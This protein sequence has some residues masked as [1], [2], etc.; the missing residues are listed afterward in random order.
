[1]C[2]S[3]L[4]LS[5]CGGGSE[6][7]GPYTSPQVAKAFA[8][9]TGD[10]LTSA[11]G[12]SNAIYEVLK[13]NERGDS[14]A[15]YERYGVFSVYVLNKE[16]ARD[17]VYRRDPDTKKAIKPSSDGIY[18]RSSTSGGHVSWSAAKPFK[19]AVLTW[20]AGE[21]QQTDERWNRLVRIMRALDKSPA[22][23][24]A[25]LPPGDQ[26]CAQ[27]GIDPVRGKTGTC[28]LE[29]QTLVLANRSGPLTLPAL[30][31]VRVD[32]V[33]RTKQVKRRYLGARRAR[34]TYVIVRYTVKNTGRAPLSFL[35]PVLLIGDRSYES[36]SRT[37]FDV[38]PRRFDAYP[39]QPDQT[40]PLAAVFDVPPAAA[41]QV[42]AA[43][44]LA[45]SGDER[46][47]GSS[48]VPNAKTV[49]RIRLNQ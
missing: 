43:G 24:R 5:A 14:L 27:Q 12:A 13:L 33:R 37:E 34:G 19:N 15:S 1:M 16:Q 2:L 25:L 45:I 44:A 17:I 6:K 20:Q 41:A 38:Q 46:G 28:K 49:G 7:L 47:S 35:R 21:R 39:I 9:A 3:G 22:Q 4:V 8:A 40:T 30:R 10:A 29:E 31:V 36:D 23:L 11:P 42:S 48:S 26:P 32:A 18:W